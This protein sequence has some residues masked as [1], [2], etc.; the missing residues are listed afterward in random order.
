M[1]ENL[2]TSRLFHVWNWSVIKNMSSLRR[3]NLAHT[4]SSTSLEEYIYYIIILSAREEEANPDFLSTLLS[5]IHS[6]RQ[7]H[8]VTTFKIA[9]RGWW[10][11]RDP[12][13]STPPCLAFPRGFIWHPSQLSDPEVAQVSNESRSWKACFGLA[14]F[15]SPNMDVWAC[16]VGFLLADYTHLHNITSTHDNKAVLPAAIKCFWTVKS[17]RNVLLCYR[18]IY[19]YIYKH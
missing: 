7:R 8:P 6:F 19:I 16:A 1:R 13:A 3:L 18:T 4:P 2:K 5:T 11:L 15:A 10:W 9:C 14:I 17:A 12:R